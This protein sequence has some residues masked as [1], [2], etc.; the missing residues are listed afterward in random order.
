MEQCES[1]R[2]ATASDP[3]NYVTIKPFSLCFIQ[4]FV[5]PLYHQF[6]SE[7]Y[8]S[9]HYTALFVVNAFC[10]LN[11]IEGILNSK[12][13]LRLYN[14][15]VRRP[16]FVIWTKKCVLGPVVDSLL[17]VSYLVRHT[18]ALDS[19]ASLRQAHV[20]LKIWS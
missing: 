18:G 4:D 7:C 13:F 16:V 19:I 6:Q 8:R 20:F 9:L 14:L 5:S 11:L 10:I 17:L 2:Y 1:L 3:N 15:F 12:S